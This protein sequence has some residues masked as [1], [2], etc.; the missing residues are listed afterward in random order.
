MFSF[1]ARAFLPWLIPVL[2]CGTLGAYALALIH[3]TRFFR[4][5][6]PLRSIGVSAWLALSFLFGLRIVH[7]ILLL[8]GSLHLGFRFSLVFVGLL[9][10]GAG[11]MLWSPWKK[12]A[13]PP[14]EPWARSINHRPELTEAEV[15]LAAF[16]LMLFYCA[17]HAEPAGFDVFTHWWVVPHEILSFDRMAYFYGATRSVAPDY[18]THQIVLGAV[19]SL[20]SGGRDGIGNVFSLL[21]LTAGA[22]A[23]IEAAWVL[24]KSRLLVAMALLA[25]LTIAGSPEIVFGYFY[26]DALVIAVVALA[27][28]GLA[29]L[30]KHRGRSSPVVVLA[31][32]SM[33]LMAKG[34]GLHLCLLGVFLFASW[35]AWSLRR[36]PLRSPEWKAAGM[37]VAVLALELALP[38]LFLIGV[39]SNHVPP[40][41]LTQALAGPVK[42]F[43]TTAF[44]NVYET[45]AMLALGVA[46]GLAPLL[47]LVHPRRLCRT[48]QRWMVAL[49]L[50]YAMAVL[51]VF[52]AATLL[53]PASNISWPR[54]ATMGAPVIGILVTIGLVHARRWRVMVSIPLLAAGIYLLFTTGYHGYIVR[55]STWIKEGWAAVP[56]RDD[57]FVAKKA[58][59][60]NLRKAVDPLQGRVFLIIADKNELF[61]PYQISNH[62]A[63]AGIRA[64]LISRCYTAPGRGLALANIMD[65]WIFAKG[66]KGPPPAELNP[67]TDFLYLPKPVVLS[68]R[69]FR[70]LVRLDALLAATSR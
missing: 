9:S 15:G 8:L 26:G 2:A 68:G 55:H 19:A 11:I 32:L 21:F 38:R 63:M 58:F 47:A 22:L 28:L 54:Y 3:R 61:L 29:Y 31:C 45:P 69:A 48:S 33:P 43:I 10:L 34:I 65:D 35:Q 42:A 27:L 30:V 50:I 4:T 17:L 12:A 23:V 52:I 6:A 24:S 18:P 14:R 64:T 49:F 53:A 1:F 56:V 5:A 59:Y 16:A 13:Q 51:S 57:V 41:P 62:F 60:E 44:S 25:M 36:L 20:I 37:L 40:R 7:L 39:V 70:D 46:I 67:A 66:A